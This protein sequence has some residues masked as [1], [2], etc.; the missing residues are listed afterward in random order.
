MRW[1]GTTGQCGASPKSFCL[2]NITNTTSYVIKCHKCVER[3]NH[4]NRRCQWLNIFEMQLTNFYRF[5]V[6]QQTSITSFSRAT[7]VA[8]VASLSFPSSSLHLPI[9]K[10]LHIP[11][12]DLFMTFLGLFRN[13]CWTFSITFRDFIPLGFLCVPFNDHNILLRRRRLLLL[14]VT[15]ALV[16]VAS[17]R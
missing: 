14:R 13:L 8:H 2:S 7:G 12:G 15:G 9:S 1:H 4:L 10:S 5:D 6:V 17:L 11:F 3:S 16:S